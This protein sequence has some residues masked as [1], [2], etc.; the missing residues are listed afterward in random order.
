MRLAA[1]YGPLQGFG[2]YDN[3]THLLAYVEQMLYHTP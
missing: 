3:M 1:S 2:A